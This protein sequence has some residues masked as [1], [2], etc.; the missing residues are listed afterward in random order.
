MQLDDHQKQELMN[1]LSAQWKEP[2]VCPVCKQQ[3][4]SIVDK[5]FELREFH[6]GNLV[7][8]GSVLPIVVAICGNCGYTV[9]FNAISLGI[10]Q[11][12]KKESK[13]E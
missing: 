5:I 13:D 6:G 7:V 4:W 8:G 1:I 9:F 3:K 11:P 10:V 2:R 12:Q